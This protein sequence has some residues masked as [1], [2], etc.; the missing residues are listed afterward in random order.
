LNFL[1]IFYK[2]TQI[3]N[4]MNSINWEQLFHTDGS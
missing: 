3:P 2:N 1:D 4:F